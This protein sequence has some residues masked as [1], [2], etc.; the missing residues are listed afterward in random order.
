MTANLAPEVAFLI[1]FNL[2]WVPAALGLNVS[3]EA[4]AAMLG[5]APADF[6]EY[7]GQAEQ[8]VKRV[9]EKLLAQPDLQAAIDQLPIPAG[10]T[11]L[12]VGD[13]ITTYRY[14]YARLL[15]AMLELRRPEDQIRFVNV[16]QSGYTSTHA[17]ENTYTQFLAHQ[18]DWVV[19][20]YGANDC[21][22]FGGPQAKT[23]VSLNEY[24]ANM[25][26]IVEAFL[27]H[28]SARPVLLTPTPVVASITNQLPE[29]I[30]MRMTW[31]NDNLQACAE[32]IKDLAREHNLPVVDLMSLFTLDPDPAFYVPD[33]LHPNPA[34]QQLIL[35]Q[36]LRSL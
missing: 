24:R 36:L 11:A 6:L 5:I 25:T 18:P 27:Q 7:A 35:E 19:I 13:S 21:K 32:V 26:A 10:G 33:G 29:F 31:N 23:L 17:L 15:Q 2:H 3:T 34:G 30:A 14:G 12:A 20:K 4:A 8:E 22:Q 28:T 1:D 9:A 16:A